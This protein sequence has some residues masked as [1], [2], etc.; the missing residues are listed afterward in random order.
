L[1][2]KKKL[3]DFSSLLF[4]KSIFT[5]LLLGLGFIF[6]III[7]LSTTYYFSSGL[8][9]THGMKGAIIKINNK[10]LEPFLGINILEYDRYLDLGKIKIKHL[11]IKTEIE[12]LNLVVSQKTILQIENQ[13]KLKKENGGLLPPKFFNM[14][15]I[16]IKNKDEEYKAK[17]RIKGVRPIHWKDKR[18]SSYKIDLIGENRIWGMEEFTVQKPITKNYAYEFLFHK[19]LSKTNNLYLKYFPIMLYFNDENRGVYAVEE[20]FSKELLERQKKRNGPIFSLNEDIGEWYPNVNY[21]LYSSSYWLEE[22]PELAESAFSILNQ[23]KD[24]DDLNIENHF[25]MDKWASYFAAIDLLGSYHGSLAKSI[26]LYFNPTSS[27]FE[28]IGYDAHIGAGNFSNFIFADFLQEGRQN[29]IYICEEKEWYLKFFKLKNNQINSDFLEKYIYYLKLYSSEDFINEFLEEIKDELNTFNILVYSENSKVDKIS[30]KGI[31]PYLY[32]NQMIFERAKLIKNRINSINI[33][34]IK[35][36][37]KNKKLFFKD[38]YSNFPI[39]ITTDNCDNGISKVFYLAGN[40][41]MDWNNGCKKILIGEKNINYFLKEDISMSKKKII[42]ISKDFINLAKYR[43]VE[44]MSENTFVISKNLDLNENFYIGKNQNFL[45][46]KNVIIRLLNNSILFIKGNIKFKGTEEKKILVKSDGTGSIIFENNNVEISNTNFEN[47]GYP[48]LEQYTLFSGLNFIKSNVVLENLIIKKSK[49]EDAINL[50]D[51]Q[52]SIKN[53]H[54]EDIQSDG[55]DIDFG[56]VKFDKIY[57]L[58][59]KNDCLDISGAKVD[60]IK[61]EVDGSLDK[62]LSIGENSTVK[63]ENLI[64][65]NS[66]LAIAVKDG[67][68]SYIKNF[69]S[70]NNQYDIALFKKK[71]EYSNSSLN[72]KNF[73]NIKKKI[74]QS[75]KSVLIVGDKNILGKE[76]NSYINSI[77][78]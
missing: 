62:G 15:P 27:K 70:L 17:I 44:K 39:K 78:Y 58:K 71:K 61:L 18:A 34:N 59:I 57:C 65:Q 12:Q 46:D 10:I 8:S 5:K 69:N 43:G 38:N 28:P 1:L 2:I 25:D 32:D 75:K 31:G 55:I 45:V 47:L 74:L 37:L 9:N 51:S 14:H 42:N 4:I 40:M 6:S 52:V 7:I 23:L 60:G 50:V 67:S 35:I 63:I 30:R 36:S 76:T 48:K 21:E 54:L 19:L 11:F 53:I 66:K 64:V 73:Y 56:V 26:R 77:L 72:I 41:S 29:C 20:S 68:N 33:E 13:R 3:I 49:S 24:N 22:Y 16:K